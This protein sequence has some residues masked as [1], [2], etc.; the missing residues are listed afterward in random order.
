MESTL[1]LSELQRQVFKWTAYNFP[2]KKAYQPLLG[3]FEE[4]GELAHAHLKQEQGIR[5]TEVEH[6]EAKCDAIADCIIYL[7][8]YANKQGIDLELAITTAWL[9]VS[10][11]DW[12]NFPKNGLTE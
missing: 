5:G 2:N 10:Q 9:S 7:A 1:T 4:L 3:A 11:R 12:I 8:D 6:M